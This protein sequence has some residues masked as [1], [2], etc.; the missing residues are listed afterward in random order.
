M[1]PVTVHIWHRWWVWGWAALM[2]VVTL[3]VVF[4]PWWWWLIIMAAGFGIPEAWAIWH[5]PSATP[6]LTSIIRRYLPSYIT[7]PLFGFLIG[8]IP[9][10]LIAGPVYAVI[11]G[12]AAGFGFWWLEHFG[13]T[14][15]HRTP[16]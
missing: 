12:A 15:A 11:I 9:A 14:F 1:E 16:R 4:L 6:P 8:G 7:Y 10:Y 3:A 2:V 13:S 5:Q